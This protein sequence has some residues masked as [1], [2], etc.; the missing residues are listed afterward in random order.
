MKIDLKPLH[1][2]ERKL[3][4]LN[5]AAQKQVLARGMKEATSPVVPQAQRKLEQND[6][7]DTGALRA[8]MTNVVRVYRQGEH[9][10]GLVGPRTDYYESGVRIKK[11]PGETKEEYLERNAGKR[12]PAN[13]AHLVEYGFIHAKSG[14]RI[15]PRPFLKPAFEQEVPHMQK[16]LADAVGEAAT[17]AFED[18]KNL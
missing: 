13:Y 18:L 5:L 3:R 15:P 4:M 8:S 14:K 1:K 10:L 17:K 16:T 7:I 2:L 11:E 12:K 6:S 9:Y